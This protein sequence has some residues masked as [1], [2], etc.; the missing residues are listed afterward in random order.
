MYECLHMCVYLQNNHERDIGG[1]AYVRKKNI[2][3]CFIFFFLLLCDVTQWCK[4]YTIK[5]TDLKCEDI[6]ANK[7]QNTRTV[8]S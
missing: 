3:D 4:F 5:T 8:F 7:L 1:G 6:E 2:Y